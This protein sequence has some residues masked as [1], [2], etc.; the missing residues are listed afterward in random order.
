MVGGLVFLVVGA[1]IGIGGAVAAVFSVWPGLAVAGLVAGLIIVGVL[2]LVF[3]YLLR[4][5]PE[6]GLVW[7]I[8][9]VVIALVSLPLAFGGF[10]IGFLLTLVGGI[11][12]V[13]GKLAPVVAPAS[14]AE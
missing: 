14:H 13:T 9:L 10:V 4:H 7:G 6:L 1:I 8:L 11:L 5:Q 12:A 3:G 2:T